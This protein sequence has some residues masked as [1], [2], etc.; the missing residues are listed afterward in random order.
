VLELYDGELALRPIVAPAGGGDAALAALDVA[1]DELRKL[2]Q[3]SSPEA[4]EAAAEVIRQ[5]ELAGGRVHVTGVGKPEHVAS[6]AAAL[7]SSTG[8]PATFLHGT[9]AVHGSAGQVVAG[10]VVMAISNSG[11]TRELREA[12]EC[13]RGLGARV[14]AVTGSPDSWLGREA[15]VV[16]DAGVAREG[17]GLGL[18]PRASAAAEVVV[19]AALAALL[20]ESRDFGPADYAARHPSGELG[21]RARDR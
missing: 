2:R 16:L 4:F 9:E 6:Y 19:V 11:E 12:V 7:L 3:R 17:G 18:A 1:I 20:E 13:V 10:D 5:A 15:E 21:R 14:I 8:T